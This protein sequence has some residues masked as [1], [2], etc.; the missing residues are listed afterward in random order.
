MVCVLQG[1]EFSCHPSTKVYHYKVSSRNVQSFFF[2]SFQMG[3]LGRLLQLVVKAWRYF[4]GIP[5]QREDGH[6]RRNYKIN[7]H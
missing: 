5:T 1:Q 2:H 4:Q 3:N 7:E 6:Q